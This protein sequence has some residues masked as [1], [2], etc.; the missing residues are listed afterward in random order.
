M[1]SY[2]PDKFIDHDTRT[3]AISDG[4]HH[5]IKSWSARLC[6]TDAFIGEKLIICDFVQIYAFQ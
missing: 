3:F 4:G 5:S 2:W 1:D 6:S